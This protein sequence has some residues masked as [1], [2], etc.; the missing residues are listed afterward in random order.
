[1]SFHSDIHDFT[2]RVRE[3]CFRWRLNCSASTNAKRL[4][5]GIQRSR[6]VKRQAP[7][8]PQAPPRSRRRPAPKPPVQKQCVSECCSYSSRTNPFGCMQ[9]NRELADE[10]LRRNLQLALDGL[11]QP[12]PTPTPTPALSPPPSP[13]ESEVP[14]DM[15]A[16]ESGGDSVTRKSRHNLLSALKRSIFRPIWQ[17]LRSRQSR[18]KFKNSEANTTNVSACSRD[19][20]CSSI[21]R[22]SCFYVYYQQ[23]NGW[24]PGDQLATLETSPSDATPAHIWTP[25]KSIWLYI[26]VTIKTVLKSP[27]NRNRTRAGLGFIRTHPAISKKQ[28]PNKR[29]KRQTLFSHQSCGGGNENKA[30]RNQK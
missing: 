17:R 8:P 3:C 18:K 13:F 6:P 24:G 25:S 30:T 28:P 16:P 4:I 20:S 29:P 12:L 7:L 10:Y 11:Q 15:E 19:S 22:S 26:F 9:R 1:M 23:R 5:L 21:S 27:R 14:S 2:R